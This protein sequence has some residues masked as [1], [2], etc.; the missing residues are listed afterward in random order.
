MPLI[1]L[2]GMGNAWQLLYAGRIYSCD[3]LVN[4]P[5]FNPSVPSVATTALSC[6]CSAVPTPQTWLYDDVHGLIKFLH[7]TDCLLSQMTADTKT[8]C[9]VW[10]QG[11]WVRSTSAKSEGLDQTWVYSQKLT[12]NLTSCQRFGLRPDLRP[13]FGLSLK[14][15]TGLKFIFGLRPELN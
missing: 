6:K 13:N 14:A 10:R 2:P 12:L 7:G 5:P 9:E 3:G 15:K 4:V 11:Q 8:S 1:T